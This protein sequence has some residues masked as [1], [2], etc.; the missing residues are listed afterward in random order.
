MPRRRAIDIPAPELSDEQWAKL[1]E[2][3]PDEAGSPYGGPKPVPTRSAAGAALVERQP[4]ID[5]R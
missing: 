4:C 1:A 2:W 3:L 5:G